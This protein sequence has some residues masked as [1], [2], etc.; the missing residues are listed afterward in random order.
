MLD[1][2]KHIRLCSEL[3]ETTGQYFSITIATEDRKEYFKKPE[4]AT[5]TTELIM[6]G[7]I[8]KLATLSAFCLMPDH[9]HLLIAPE[10]ASL[11]HLIQLWKSYTTN[12][13]CKKLGVNVK[14]WQR[15]IYDHALRKE[16]DIGVVAEYILNNPVRKDLV[17][18][19]EEYPY[20]W[21]EWLEK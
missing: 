18:N 9:L 12:I 4:I 2:R 16:E 10:N 21:C 11:I 7:N 17:K 13:I 5:L 20:S 1:K 3:Y 15:S 14:I 19:W 6:S 8:S